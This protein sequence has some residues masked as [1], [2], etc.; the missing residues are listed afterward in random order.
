MAKLEDKNK[1]IKKY[2]IHTTDTGSPEVQIAVL[3]ERIKDL[4]THLKKHPQDVDS[5]RGLLEIIA[6]RRKI[7]MYLEKK[8]PKRYNSL[9]K[10]IKI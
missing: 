1:I 9:M 4:A 8:Y 3:T 5:K 2:R 10:H 6:K 7:L